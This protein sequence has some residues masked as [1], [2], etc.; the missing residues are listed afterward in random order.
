MGTGLGRSEILQRPVQ[1]KE[2][3]AMSAVSLVFPHHLFESNPAL[4]KSRP[5]ILVEEFLFFKQ[6]KFHKQKLVFHRASMMAYFSFLQREG[7]QVT[8]MEAHDENADV[9]RLLSSLKEQGVVE[10]H[11][12]EVTDCWLEQRLHAK[13]KQLR[14]ILKAYDSPLFVLTRA[15]ME[16]YFRN[17]KRFY[18]TDFYI[19]QRKRY[20]ILVDE[21]LQPTGGQWTYD[22][23]NRLKYPK[24][25]VPPPIHFPE[26]NRFWPEAKKYVEQNFAANYG[27]VN[28]EFYLPDYF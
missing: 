11:Y 13:A 1:E 17:R 7:Y 2:I 20:Q 27:E 4:Q 23:A 15:E 19:H 26:P 18:Q 24:G 8:Y 5:V 28:P 21:K 9:R 25:K 16:D 12:A 3:N 14:L 22:V 10:I 6:Y